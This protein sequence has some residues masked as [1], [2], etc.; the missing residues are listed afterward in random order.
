M[1]PDASRSASVATCGS[2]AA[3]CQGAAVSVNESSSHRKNSSPYAAASAAAATSRPILQFRRFDA[4]GEFD[5]DHS[6][7][8]LLSGQV[9]I[10][11]VLENQRHLR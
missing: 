10:D 6:F 7:G 4:F 3:Q 5:S 8:H 1:A 2:S 9:D 11:T